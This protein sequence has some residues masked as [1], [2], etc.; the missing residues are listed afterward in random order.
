MKSD[1]FDSL[2]HHYHYENGQNNYNHGV[3]SQNNESYPH[4]QHQQQS[5]PQNNQ[6]QNHL[7]SSSQYY[8]ERKDSS[9]LDQFVDFSSFLPSSSSSQQL[10]PDHQHRYLHNNNE[11]FQFQNDYDHDHAND[12]TNLEHKD[13][14]TT[15]YCY[16][17]YFKCC[18]GTY[19]SE[20]RLN[21]GD[22][23]V[24]DADRGY[25]VGVISRPLP[26][27]FDSVQLSSSAKIISKLDDQDGIIKEMLL[28][29]INLENKALIFARNSC[30]EL[31]VTHLL[32]VVGTEFQ[33]DK[34]KLI[35]YYQKLQPDVSLCKLIRK[36]YGVFKMRI[37]MENI[38]I[39]TDGESLNM[40]SMFQP[41]AL[42]YLEL[43]S[44]PLSQDDVYI[45]VPGMK[46]IW[47]KYEQNLEIKDENTDLSDIGSDELS[48]VSCDSISPLSSDSSSDSLN[49]NSQPLQKYNESSSDSGYGDHL[50]V[51]VA[52]LSPGRNLAA[53]LISSPYEPQISKGSKNRKP[54]PFI[55]PDYL[56][57]QPQHLLRGKL[58]SQLPPPAPSQKTVLY[59][60]RN[61]PTSSSSTVVPIKIS[62]LPPETFHRIPYYTSASNPPPP[63]HS[64]QYHLHNAN[65]SGNQPILI[66]QHH[67]HHHH[68][69]APV[70]TSHN[71]RMNNVHHIS[72]PII[73]LP[74]PG[75]IKYHREI[76]QRDHLMNNNPSIIRPNPLHHNAPPPP[77][78]HYHDSHFYRG[79]FSSQDQYGRGFI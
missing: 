36:L 61:H 21:Q 25:D 20:L 56:Q 40:L 15:T 75:R 11:T 43:T 10:Q 37:W 53:G 7:S 47:S 8:Q 76:T 1:N 74:D 31:N 33:F 28:K 72:P 60:E 68:I 78:A 44:L 34:K 42:K 16:E 59:V 24:V 48:S 13:H 17:V 58:Q 5:H 46:E 52:S 63:H 66:H 3:E 29:K 41:N 77:P 12:E 4:L 2:Y 18:N 6:N 70:V 69:S 9:E 51:K 71:P 50:P 30:F 38:T 64:S 62:H 54:K 57:Y 55:H 22:L 79:N 35:V 65:S 39:D 26:S 19:I 23:V 49:F 45:F 67:H 14:Q 32:H 73:P 27:H